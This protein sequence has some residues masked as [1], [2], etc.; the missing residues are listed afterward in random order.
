MPVAISPTLIA[1]IGTGAWVL[2]LAAA[3]GRRHGLMFG[4]YGLA[5]AT[6]ALAVFWAPLVVALLIG[7]RIPARFWPI[8]PL[9]FLAVTILLRL[10]AWPVPDFAAIYVGQR[11]WSPVPVA[12]TPNIWAIVQALPWLGALPLAGLAV[13]ATVGASAWFTARF[14][15][16]PPAGSDVIAS[17]VLL[18]LIVASLMPGRDGGSFL[19]VDI[20]ALMLAVTRGDRWSW[21]VFALSA[22]GSMLGIAGNLTDI[23][24]CAIFGAVPVMAA[25]ALIARQF[26]VSPANDNGLPLNPFHAYP[27][28]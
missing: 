11:D 20:L 26:L 25:A 16:R 10:A 28:R 21:T 7:R 9:S 27:A 12:D 19:M 6:N 18:A 22:T 17:G 3:V 14:A 4:W 24:A 5:L 13:T 8:A 1:A 2:A 23:S 15:W